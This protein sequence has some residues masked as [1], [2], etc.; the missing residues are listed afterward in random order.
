M[1]RAARLTSVKTVSIVGGVAA[2]AA[3]AASMRNMA[4]CEGL[5]L[6]IPDPILCT[7]NAAMI[8][9]LGGFQ[10]MA[11]SVNSLEFDTFATEMLGDSSE[12][13]A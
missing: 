5:R 1:R 13:S 6:V 3:L 9:A 4:N 8:A 7:D 2:N 10:L 11:G 12:R